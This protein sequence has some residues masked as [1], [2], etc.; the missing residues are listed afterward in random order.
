MAL[1]G[2][3]EKQ[4]GARRNQHE[5]CQ[6][7]AAGGGGQGRRPTCVCNHA[8]SNQGGHAVKRQAA[9]SPPSWTPLTTGGGPAS[10]AL[11]PLHAGVLPLP[12]APVKPRAHPADATALPARVGAATGQVSE[13]SSQLEASMAR[14]GEAERA[15]E[16]VEGSL[17]G[18]VEAAESAAARYRELA[19]RSESRAAQLSSAIADMKAH[20]QVGSAHGGGCEA[21]F[22]VCDGGACVG[23]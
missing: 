12:R 19:G 16:E 22:A 5:A 8:C 15:R 20:V 4:C 9:P 2:R 1:E 18:Q 13:L 23:M 17:R 3:A 14:Q 7:L 11:H 6:G 10:I 21:E